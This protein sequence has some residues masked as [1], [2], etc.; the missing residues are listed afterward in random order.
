MVII[1]I[2][3][4]IGRMG[5]GVIREENGAQSMTDCGCFE[6][7]AKLAEEKRLEKIHD[8]IKE[9]VNKYSPDVVAVESLFFAANSKTA[10]SVGQ[11]RGVILLTISQAE[12]KLVSYTPLQVK[13]SISGYGKADKNQVQQMVKSL[14]KLKQIPKPDDAADALAIALTYAYSYKVNNKIL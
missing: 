6:T 10:F 3:P 14:L 11:A 5:W 12:V 4:G 7:D 1:G 8:F 13:L 9:L 2:D